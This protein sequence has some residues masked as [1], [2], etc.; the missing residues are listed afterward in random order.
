MELHDLVG[1]I[2]TLSSNWPD[3]PQVYQHTPDT[4]RDLLTLHE[5]DEL[6]DSNCLAA[7]NVVLL[8]KEDGGVVESHEYTDGDMPRPGTVREHLDRGGSIS[9][10]LLHTLYPRLAILKNNVQGATLCRAH[11]NAYLTPGR[12]QG[13]RY[14]YDPYV[15]LIVQLHGRK[16]WPLHKPMVERPTEEHEN[17]RLRGW[18]DEEH[19]FLATTPPAQS[20]TLEP[21]NV[22][23][24]PRGW[25]HAPYAV[26]EEPSLH[27]TVALKERTLSWLVE[28]LAEI[29]VRH[30][31]AD[32]DARQVLAPADLLAD[33]NEALEWTRKYM[34][35]ALIGLDLEATMASALNK[36]R[37]T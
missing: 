20:V 29:I 16:T 9:L 30:A 6:I 19:K 33:P 25:I 2:D 23:W 32:F 5:I 15:T 36:A 37:T 11:V 34:I 31:R 17:F 10:R 35:G 18:T 4:F 26:S 27:I 7:R 3:Q 12:Q 21:G 14:H 28:H 13:L 1:P 24:L 22:F 8:R